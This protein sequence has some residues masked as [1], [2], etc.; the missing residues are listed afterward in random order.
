MRIEDAV[1]SIE[2]AIDKE[3]ADISQAISDASD[4]LEM[5]RAR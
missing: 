4:G 5:H 1:E 3:G 2:T